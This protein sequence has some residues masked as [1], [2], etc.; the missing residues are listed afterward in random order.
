MSVR[1]S[2][3]AL[4][5]VLTASSC[6]LNRTPRERKVTLI[7]KPTFKKES[8]DAVG[9]GGVE[10]YRLRTGEGES[11]RSICWPDDAP[12][13]R[14]LSKTKNYTIDLVEEEHR[15][16]QKTVW[17]PELV[18]VKD[19]E[20]VLHDASVCRVHK[21]QM[22]REKVR[23]FYGLPSFDRD[24]LKQAKEFPNTG[25]SLGGCSISGIDPQTTREWICP[26]CLMAMNLWKQQ[27][28]DKAWSVPKDPRVHWNLF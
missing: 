10:F 3:L 11:E 16:G 15:I 1:N 25:L 9:S 19:G 20:Q 24:Y 18:R 28:P 26:E 5:I 8:L 14:T 17:F 4:L 7:T 21:C 22:T 23:I 13:P 27:H 12:R 6:S 2:I